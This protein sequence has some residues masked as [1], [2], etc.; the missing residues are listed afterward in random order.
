[1][2][3][4]HL[5]KIAFGI[6]IAL[7]LNGVAVAKE[8]YF[9]TGLDYGSQGSYNPLSV[10]LNGGFDIFQTRTDH[11][12]FRYPYKT[13]FSNVF[14]NLGHAD[15]VVKNYGGRNFFSEQ[16]F[17]LTTD[18]KKWAWWPNYSLHLIGGGVEWAMLHEFFTYHNIPVP[19]L[20]GTL[21]YWSYHFLNEAV[22]NGKYQGKSVDSIADI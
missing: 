19:W 4:N 2:H 16:I 20:W 9:Y 5:L 13:A 12:V 10:I 8:Y 17:P 21:T 14:D 6:A 18:M 3:G 1:M 15:A 7:A 22:E 11:E